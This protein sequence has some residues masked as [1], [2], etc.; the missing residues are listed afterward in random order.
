[1]KPA[2]ANSAM[3]SRTF[4]ETSFIEIL[5]PKNVKFVKMAQNGAHSKERDSLSNFCVD[6]IFVKSIFFSEIGLQISKIS[7]KS[8]IFLQNL[9]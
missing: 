9:S 4:L 2:T 6:S 5:E 1:M 8:R 3:V 7:K